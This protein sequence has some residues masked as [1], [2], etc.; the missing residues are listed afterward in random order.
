LI[1]LLDTNTWIAYLKGNQAVLERIMQT[2]RL[3]ITSISLGELC[4]GARKSQR[5]E[6]NL[7]RVETLAS[8]VQI[9]TVDAL[10]AQAYGMIRADLERQGTPIG[11]N[12]LWIAAVAKANDLMLVTR[13]QREF[14]RVVGLRLE[15]W[16]SDS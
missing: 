15:D 10:T 13:N 14:T 7:Q 12:D 11:P 1:Y 16:E 3:G 9:F 5:V 4:Y 6:A 8:E 2:P